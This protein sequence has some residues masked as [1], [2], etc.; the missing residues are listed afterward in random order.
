MRRLISLLFL[1]TC[2]QTAF[3]LERVPLTPEIKVHVTKDTLQVI[4]F[5]YRIYE[6]FVDASKGIQVQAQGKNLL[7]RWYPYYKKPAVIAVTLIDDSGK[8]YDYSIVAIPDKKFP[9]VIEVYIPDEVRKRELRRKAAKFEKGMPY[10]E[11]LVSLVK[12]FMTGKYP[13]YY[14]VEDKNE[15]LGVFRE[16]DVVLEKIGKGD[17]FFVLK[18]K[19]VNKLDR[20]IKLD[21]TSLSFLSKMYDVRAI[22]LRKHTLTPGESTVFVVVV[23]NPEDE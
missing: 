15:K 1:F 22:S 10:E 12:Q 4:K 13:D 23:S 8:T 3:A 6:A 5:P 17:K 7:I 18:G 21:E 19:V 16:I 9:E 11:L 14:S 20:P 2:F